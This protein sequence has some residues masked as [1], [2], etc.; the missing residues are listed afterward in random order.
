M[1]KFNLTIEDWDARCAAQAMILCCSNGHIHV[2]KYLV[3]TF[4]LKNKCL[5][6]E[7]MGALR[8]CCKHGHIDTLKYIVSAFGFTVEDVRSTRV[9][10]STC[11]R[12]YLDIIKYLVETFQVT[13]E[14]VCRFNN[15]ALKASCSYG[16]FPVVKYLEDKFSFQYDN[17]KNQIIPLNLHKQH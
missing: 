16:N 15:Y 11:E 12:G 8:H 1:E 17:T 3:D 6:H 10:H 2:V 4:H 7:K 5:F 14:D 13:L 9:F